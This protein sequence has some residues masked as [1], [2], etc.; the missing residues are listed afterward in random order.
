MSILMD[1]DVHCNRVPIVP[2]PQP[3]NPIDFCTLIHL[4]DNDCY[5]SHHTTFRH[6]GEGEIAENAGEWKSIAGEVTLT[7]Y[8]H[9]TSVSC[10][11]IYSLEKPLVLSRELSEKPFQELNTK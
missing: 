6:W 3:Q 10:F 4:R 7:V 11:D 9:S 1:D 2:A 8:Y 5:S